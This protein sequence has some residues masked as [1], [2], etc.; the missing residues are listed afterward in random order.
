M[1]SD[2]TQPRGDQDNPTLAHPLPARADRIDHPLD[3]LRSQTIV[4][5]Q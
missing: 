3:I 1:A 4:D 5:G 2:V